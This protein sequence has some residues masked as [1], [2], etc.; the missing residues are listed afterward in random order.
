MEN[1]RRFVNFGVNLR[2]FSFGKQQLSLHKRQLNNDSD[3]K[4]NQK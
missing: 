4:T 3:S 2:S 1:S